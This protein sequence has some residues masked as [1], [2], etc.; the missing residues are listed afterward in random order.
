MYTHSPNIY[1]APQDAR[2]GLKAPVSDRCRP[3]VPLEG[4]R[5]TGRLRI[6][7][8]E[9]ELEAKAGCKLLPGHLERG[10]QAQGLLPMAHFFPVCEPAYVAVPPASHTLP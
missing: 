1:W 5:G 3:A 6:S 7:Q 9:A 2:P 4:G 10:W 8:Q